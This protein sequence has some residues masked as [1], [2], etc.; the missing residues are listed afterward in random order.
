MEQQSNISGPT[1]V[2]TERLY[3]A[4]R[5]YGDRLLENID[6]ETGELH[7]PFETLYGEGYGPALAANIF[8]GLYVEFDEERYLT[9]ARLSLKRVFDKLRNPTDNSPFTDIF[10]YFWSLKAYRLLERRRPPGEMERWRELFVGSDYRFSPP[11]TNGYCLLVS[12]AL[13][14]EMMGF[15]SARREELDRMVDT[16]SSM[17]N[18]SGFIDDAMR[19]HSGPVENYKRS[20][21]QM[22]DKVRFRFGLE[23]SS[24]RDLKP[25]AYHIFCCAV[26]AESIMMGEQHEK[27]ELGPYKERIAEIVN[28]GISWI[29]K[30][31]GT[32][33][34]VS[35]TERSRDQMWTGMCY[36]YILA[37]RGTRKSA[38]LMGRHID[39]W[40][41]FLKKDGTCSVAPNY[42]SNGLRVGFEHYSIMSMYVSLG[43]SYLLDIADVLSGNRTIDGIVDVGA[44]GDDIW[45][46]EEAGYIHIRRGKSSSAVS[47]RRHHGGYFGGYCPAMGLFN[48][49]IDGSR[50]RPLPSPCYRVRGLGVAMSIQRSDLANNGVYEGIRAFR[51]GKSWGSDFTS[52]ARIVESADR[53]VL[54]AVHNGIEIVKSIELDDTS[55]EIA[56]AL[57]INNRLDKLLVT[58]PMLMSDG[59][60]ETEL[61]IRG[62]VVTFAFGDE[63]YR[64]S[65]KEGYDW[66]HNQERFFLSTSGI[67]SQL[68]VIVG[69]NVSSGSKLKCSLRLDKLS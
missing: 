56:Y 13:A 37:L 21:R 26:L 30:F 55:L 58:Y 45:V 15:G 10:L 54:A 16:I 51:G 62:P 53:L 67:T 20:F 52:N 59:R 43:F 8:A 41:R 24:E 66:I 33:G 42:F 69:R 34:S 3:S 31:T 9:G 23:R 17:Q 68:Y 2:D 44:G 4:V 7:D 47:L 14:Y 18:G 64:L 19:R 49:V 57:K 60:I 61:G 36:A 6:D 27:P 12:T 48:T 22:L 63:N 11:N 38:A 5:D 32:D 29:D 1:S 65:C 50:S 40:L 25:I 28:G 35:M 39:W 46:D